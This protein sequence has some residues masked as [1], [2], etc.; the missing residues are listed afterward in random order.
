MEAKTSAQPLGRHEPDDFQIP[1]RSL[2]Q[3][4]TINL[5]KLGVLG[6]AHVPGLHQAKEVMRAF[7][8]VGLEGTLDQRT[9]KG[10]FGDPRPRRA[11]SDGVMALD[12]YLDAVQ[13]PRKSQ[14]P[15]AVPTSRFFVTL[16]EDGLATRLLAPTEAKQPEIA[17]AQRS[18]EYTPESEV[19]LHFD[20]I[21]AISMSDGNG[22]VSWEKVKALAARRIMELLH[23]RWSPRGGSIYQD[24]RLR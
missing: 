2:R 15:E 3:P 4:A 21:E 23:R 16:L 22:E 10:W 13:D 6:D 12:R 1:L 11:R 5:F 18:L 24:L 7:A 8:V 9:W 19:H 17:L 14:F 20:A